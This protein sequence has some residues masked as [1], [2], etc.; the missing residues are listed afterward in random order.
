MNG[1]D[2]GGGG[3]DGGDGG[4]GGRGG[5]DATGGGGGGGG[6]LNS[7]KSNANTRIRL[8]PTDA[9]ETITRII[10]LS[11][12][13]PRHCGVANHALSR[14]QNCAQRDTFFG[15][16]ARNVMPRCK[17]M[18]RKNSGRIVAAG[19]ALLVNHVP[20]ATPEA[21]AERCGIAGMLSTLCH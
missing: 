4:R 20:L 15:G 19:L 12:V 13:S 8:P 16:G 14:A 6:E 3:G 21:R 11:K 1:G 7:G 10:H 17:G 5:N 2:D 9:T 18:G